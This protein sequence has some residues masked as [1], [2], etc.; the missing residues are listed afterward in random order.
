[1]VNNLRRLGGAEKADKGAV[2][3]ET[4]ADDEAVLNLWTFL[5]FFRQVI[6]LNTL[7][8]PVQLDT[9][10]GG[11]KIREALAHARQS[12]EVAN[13]CHG[14]LAENMDEDLVREI[15]KRTGRLRHALDNR[16]CGF[17]LQAGEAGDKFAYR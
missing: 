9:L 8:K 5:L 16:R 4:R 7:F 1:M 10:L 11:N 2:S 13:I 6:P 14:D 15:G 17:N 12:A 3:E